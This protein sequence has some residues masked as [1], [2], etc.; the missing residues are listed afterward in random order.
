MG[1][2]IHHP[3]FY[4]YTH[5]T[6]CSVHELDALTP[7]VVSLTVKN[8]GCNEVFFTVLNLTRFVNL[9][10]FE[11]G[12]SSFSYVDTVYLIGLS[13]LERV[14][15]G[16]N[17][18]MGGIYNSNSVLRI[19]NT[20]SL[21]ELK[22]GRYSFKGYSAFEIENV[23]SLEVIEIGEFNKESNNFGRSSELELKSEIDDM[24]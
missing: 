1:E 24:K 14:M 16:V 2:L 18:I 10:E 4:Y 5:V 22:I 20:D 23:P 13:K 17:S 9:K 7:I 3:A 6:I 19:N 11:V 12:D 15:I 21:K 8:Y